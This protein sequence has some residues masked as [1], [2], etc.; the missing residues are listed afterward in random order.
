MRL[1]SSRASASLTRDRLRQVAEELFAEHGIEGVTTRA[2]AEGAGANIAA[3][4]YHYGNKDNLALE[5]FR[6]VA[7][8]TARWRIDSLDRIEAEA[9]RAGRRPLVHDIV[10]AFVDAYVNE[11]SPRTGVLLAHLILKHRLQ[12]SDWTRAIV[13]EEL[14]GLAA[15]YV[16]ALR[17]ALPDLSAKQVYWR[18]HLMVGAILVALSDSGPDSR[19]ARLSKGVCSPTDRRELRAELIEFLCGAFAGDG[20]PSRLAAA[21]RPRTPPANRA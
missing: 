4:N 3:V 8:R 12:P 13:M 5:V 21:P 19:F 17:A 14:D 15:R 2:L 1:N 11:S 20:P 10:T 9:A 6:E 7:R 16:A 18:Y